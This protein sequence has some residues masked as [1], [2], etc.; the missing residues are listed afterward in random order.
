MIKNIA[1]K[2][3]LGSSFEPI[4]RQLRHYLIKLRGIEDRNWDY[5]VQTIKIMESVLASDSNCVDIGC[6]SGGLLSEIER[7]SP[8]G[9]HYAFE[10]L[11]DM[12][13]KLLNKYKSKPKITILNCALSDVEGHLK[14]QYVRSNPSYSGLRRRVYDNPDEDILEIESE[15]RTLD[16]VLPQD[17]PI[18]F[19]KID[20]EGAEY[21]VM[22]GAERTIKKHQPAIVFEYD[23]A[24]ASVYNGDPS[25]MYSFLV[26]ECGLR[27]FNLDRWLEHR[28]GNGLDEDSFINQYHEKVHYYFLAISNSGN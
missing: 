18:H 7:I 9:T 23:Y 12:H 20:V 2:L 5:D 21:D 1:R 4:A 15:V 13:E 17:L 28:E 24:G 22:K 16:N 27:I 25:S 14:F 26:N 3:L 11:P 6:Y 19:I 8:E 10:P